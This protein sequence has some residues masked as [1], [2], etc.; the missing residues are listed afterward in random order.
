M[1]HDHTR[2]PGA[3]GDL[4]LAFVLNLGF[5]ILEIFGGLWTN[6]VAILSDAVHDLGDSLSLGAAWYLDRY[7][8]RAS[9]NR[10]S[11]GYLRFSL[12]GAGTNVTVLLVGSILVLS[13][14]IPRLFSPEPAHAPGMLVFALFGIV[15]NGAAAL[16]L[17]TRHSLNAKVAAWH[18]IEDVLGW[19][20]V[21]VVSITLL[22]VDLPVLDPALSILITAYILYN[23]LRNLRQTF[24]LFL[25]AVPEDVD[26][27]QLGRRLAALDHVRSTHHT[28]VWSM[29]GAHHVLTTHIVVDDATTKEDILCLRENVSRLCEEYHFA[30]TT[31][32]IE[33]G[34]DACRMTER[35]TG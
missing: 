18:L 20:A 2:S 30:H 21:L 5:T 29:D 16:R 4:G 23:V 24:M 35:L 6:S 17:R 34:D 12:L 22:F 15:V 9:D 1:T 8:Q 14:A 26:L 27:G 11:Y 7:A 10:F 32:E 13:E 3:T 19:V 25:Q 28:H 33:W 31:I